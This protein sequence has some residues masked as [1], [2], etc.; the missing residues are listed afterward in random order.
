ME[1]PGRHRPL[2]R[3]DAGWQEGVDALAASPADGVRP[4]AE[5]RPPGQRTQRAAAE[6]AD[7]GLVAEQRCG[8]ESDRE[9]FGRRRTRAHDGDGVGTGRAL[10]MTQAVIAPS[11]EKMVPVT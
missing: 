7:P 10:H 2:R 3:R 11:I 5:T 1:R 6:S 4:D 8:I 9:R